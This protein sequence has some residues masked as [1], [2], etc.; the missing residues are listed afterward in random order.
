MWCE[1]P[2]A[3]ADFAS[4]AQHWSYGLHAQLSGSCQPGNCIWWSCC[5]HLTGIYSEVHATI[6]TYCMKA[7][8]NLLSV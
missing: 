4:V 1:L 8:N 2:S 5:H 6:L 7:W 3:T